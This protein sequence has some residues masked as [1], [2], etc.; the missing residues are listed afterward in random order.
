M[1]EPR[2][3]TKLERQNSRSCALI[4]LMIV[5][6]KG[7]LDVGLAIYPDLSMNLVVI[8]VSLTFDVLYAPS[9]CASASFSHGFFRLALAGSVP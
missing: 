6:G 9:A 2:G 3:G 8:C 5:L 4:E 1:G 7:C